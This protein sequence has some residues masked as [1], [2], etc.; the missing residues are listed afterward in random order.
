MEPARSTRS[1]RRIG[2][3]NSP[4][5]DA[6]LKAAA[7]V[8]REQGAAGLT[9]NTVAKHAGVKAHLVHYYFRSVDDMVLALVRQHGALG[10]RNT[11]RAIASDE[12]LRALWEIETAFKW[13]VVA[14]EL[15]AIAVHH[16]AVR[17][18]MMRYIEDMRRLQA[19]G[20]ARHFELRGIECPVPPVALTIMIAGIARQIVREK[21]FNVSLGHEE[22]AEVVE[23]FLASLPKRGG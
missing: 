12:P 3:Q 13:S 7:E 17:N 8:L 6:I 15:A 1:N 9:A 19:E 11:A 21:E 2:S 5:R 18:E 10:L 16:E 22:M 20:I 4:T 23:Q 14:M